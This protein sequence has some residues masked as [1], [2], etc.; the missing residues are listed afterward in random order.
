M[1]LEMSLQESTYRRDWYTRKYGNL[2]CHIKNV[3][4]EIIQE[5]GVIRSNT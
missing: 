1:I 5:G 4:E 2:D 3:T